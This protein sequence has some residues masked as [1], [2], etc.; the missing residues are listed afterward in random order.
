MVLFCP[1]CKDHIQGLWVVKKSRESVQNRANGSGSKLLPAAAAAS[2]EARK[3][4]RQVQQSGA[5]VRRIGDGARSV[6]FP[7]LILLLLEIL[8]CESAVDGFEVSWSHLENGPRVEIAVSNTDQNAH[9][10]AVVCGNCGYIQVKGGLRLAV[11]FLVL[12]MK[13]LERREV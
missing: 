4:E 10:Q 11:Y 8:E 2:C 13:K 9:R 3:R 7:G 5:E 12:S 1:H 6:I